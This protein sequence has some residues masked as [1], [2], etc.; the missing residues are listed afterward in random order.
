MVLMRCC[1]ASTKSSVWYRVSSPESC[2]CM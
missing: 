1:C 2:S